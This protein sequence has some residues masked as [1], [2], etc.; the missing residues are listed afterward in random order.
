MGQVEINRDLLSS[1]YETMFLI[2]SVDERICTEYDSRNIRGPV[3]LSIGEEAIAVGVL[4][5]CRVSDGTVSTHRCHAHY[6][7]KGGDLQPMIDEF[8]GLETGSCKGWGGS[9]HLFDKTVN[10]WGS[11]AVLGG[12]LPIACGLGFALKQT[13]DSIC[14]AF[15]GDGGTDEGVFYEALNLSALLKLPVL[16]VIENNN[17]STLTPLSRRQAQTD[18][19][20]KAESFG[21]GATRVDGNDVEAI[22]A[23]AVS[24][25]AEVRRTSQPHV[26]IAD[27]A[28][29]CAHVG[30]VS[31]RFSGIGS[32]D[33]LRIK[34]E[35]E[36]LKVF[37]S[38]FSQLAPDIDR[39]EKQVLLKV[40][41]AFESTKE[42]FRVRLAQANL[43]PPPPPNP[44]RV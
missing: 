20:R 43:P 27:T 14:V 12:S 19:S 6:L 28:R 44:S 40:N 15:T 26:L 30:P 23:R 25:V 32:D 39:R 35:G 10:M 31:Y 21:V 34:F 16:F 29:L 5:V 42:R 24:I 41:T 3:H 33:E 9:M 18:I 2:R 22:Y 13:S 38:R 7:A 11:S 37:K 1:L 8:Y 4:A 36:P 17:L